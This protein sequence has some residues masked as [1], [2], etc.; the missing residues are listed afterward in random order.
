MLNFKNFSR[1]QSFGLGADCLLN[2]LAMLIVQ[3][4]N[5]SQLNS[6]AAIKEIDYELSPLQS[7]AI[8]IKLLILTLLI[9]ECIM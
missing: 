1:D 9:V 3:A 8:I 5:N 7:F 4:I 6:D 2:T